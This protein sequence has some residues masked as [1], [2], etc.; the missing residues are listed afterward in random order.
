MMI[1][2][3]IHCGGKMIGQPK[4]M[5][6]A[7][8]HNR[9]R[10]FGQMFLSRNGSGQQLMHAR[11][12]PNRVAF[13]KQERVYALFRLKFSFLLRPAYRKQLLTGVL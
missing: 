12:P 10:G 6:L 11:Y 3:L 5:P 7:K 1:L 13:R 2:V 8:K 9:V 4:S